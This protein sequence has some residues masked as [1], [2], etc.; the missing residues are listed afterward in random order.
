MTRDLSL[1][2]S[3]WREDL[4]AT[5]RKGGDLEDLAHELGLTHFD[6]RPQW[7]PPTL[8]LCSFN[9]TLQEFS[10]A[11][12]A[13]AEIL[14]RPPDEC[15]GE[16]WLGQYADDQAPDL[17]ALW[18]T[19]VKAGGCGPVRIMVRALSPKGCKVDPRTDF[20]EKQEQDLHPE[21]KAVL[22]SLEDLEP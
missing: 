16:N 14:G 12:K 13:T 5:Y 11:V 9:M 2:C 21:C 6:A 17:V 4:D 7:G 22:A 20:V 3:K 18:K 8:D 10:D 15:K 19:E 1:P